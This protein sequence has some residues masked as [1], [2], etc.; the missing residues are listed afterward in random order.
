MF[1]HYS[2]MKHS[3]LIGSWIMYLRAMVSIVTDCMYA[4][5]QSRSQ[6]SPS[7]LKS[8]QSD[9][10][11]SNFHQT[12]LFLW[13]NLTFSSL[14]PLISLSEVFVWIQTITIKPLDL[15]MQPKASEWLN[16]AVLCERLGCCPSA[17]VVV[18]LLRQFIQKHRP[19]VTDCLE[20][21]SSSPLT[22]LWLGSSV[23]AS[24]KQHWR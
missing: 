21:H 9:Y 22:P 16:K 17:C 1:H 14:S 10:I 8:W 13:A 24:E 19:C 18:L 12:S 6:W 11:L 15:A 7:R 4:I 23:W 3:F 2:S 5:I 20:P